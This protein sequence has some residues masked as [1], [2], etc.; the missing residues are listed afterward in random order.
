MQLML[1]SAGLGSRL[2]PLTLD[3]AK[4]AV[5]FLGRPLIAGLVDLAV[6][7]GA[8]RVVINTHHRPESVRAALADH[9]AAA[10]LCFSHEPTLLGTAGGIAAAR[11]RGFIDPE[12]PLLVMNAKLS[13]ALDLAGIYAAHARLGG[14]VTMVLKPNLRREHFRE[15]LVR[16]D[17][18][19]GFGEGRV[20]KGPQPLLFTGVHVLGPAAIRA[21]RPVFSDTVRDIYPP[22]IEAGEIAALVDPRAEWSEFST[23][24]RYLSLHE[25]SWARGGGPARSLSPGAYV[26]PGA[27]AEGVVCWEGAQ[28]GAG[29][30]AR[31]AVIGAGLRLDPGRPVEGEVVVSAALCPPGPLPEGARLDGDKLYF[32]I[33]ASGPTVAPSPDDPEHAR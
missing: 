6:A 22:L 25:A 17:R 3:R 30:L 27:E 31:R 8:E 20:P 9:P 23:I 10:R 33:S 32:P 28:I 1:L 19:C 16:G 29:C 15:V 2:W 21:T 13:T 7:H 14:A 24:E 18:V 12:R 11:D 5:P 4:P 26:D